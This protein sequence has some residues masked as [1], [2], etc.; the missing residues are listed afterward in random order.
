MV[1]IG[2]LGAARI[3]PHVVINPA[4]DRDDVVMQAV[5]ARDPARAAAFA[6]A[7]GIPHVA[8]DYA[9]L[10]ARDDIDLVYVALPHSAHAEWSIRA[11]QAGK[12]VLCEKP[13]ALNADEAGAMIA[14]ASAAGRPLIEAMHYRHH[15]LMHSLIDWIRE[16]RIGRVARASGFF[17]AALPADDA[18]RWSAALGGGALLDLGCY[19]LHAMRTLMAAEPEIGAVEAEYR[20]GVDARVTAALHFPDNVVADI[21]CSMIADRRAAGLLIEGDRGRIE[22]DN[23]VAPQL[24]HKVTL[25]TRA[26]AEEFRFDGPGTFAA[27]LDH[28]VRVLR[29]GDAPL[30]GGADALANMTAIDAILAKGRAQEDGQ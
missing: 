15:R 3:A 10:I 4:K 9:N 30:C 7:H 1:R 8:A 6:Q 18:V 24:P 5:A 19:P 26:K 14:T 27:Q 11:A 21:E 16:G 17:I 20:D 13:F 12:A 28:V 29:D 25:T 2:I 23:F 22:V